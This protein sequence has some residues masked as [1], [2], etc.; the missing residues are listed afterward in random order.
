MTLIQVKI[1][2]GNDVRVFYDDANADGSITRT[3]AMRFTN[4]G[5]FEGE[6]TSHRR[7]M[8]EEST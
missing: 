1:P 3:L 8:I 7:I 6:V 5:K 4:G 2:K